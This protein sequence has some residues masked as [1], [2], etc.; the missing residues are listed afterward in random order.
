MP[1]TEK[2]FVLEDMDPAVFFQAGTHLFDT[3]QRAYPRLRCIGRG[4]EIKSSGEEEDVASF[5][6]KLRLCI[7]FYQKY[8]QLTE[9]D[10][11]RILLH[12]EEVLHMLQTTEKDIILYGN[13]GKA[14][15]ARTVNQR[16]IVEEFGHNDML[17]AIGPAG[18]GK[19]Y[20]AIALAVREFKQKNIKRIILTRPAVEA[21]EKLGY[22][23]GDVKDKLDPYLQ[24]LYDALYDMIPARRLTTYMEDGTIQIAP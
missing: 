16:R 18:T 1:M 6:E 24:P 23:P 17:F 3:L 5:E 2:T 20:T 8:N 22:L 12:E 4:N 13:N 11:N 19:T 21:G 14:I 10:L 7:A 15:T 9:A